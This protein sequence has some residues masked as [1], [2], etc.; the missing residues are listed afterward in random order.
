VARAQRSGRSARNVLAQ[1]AR[2]E[3]RVRRLSRHA[4]GHELPS[5]ARPTVRALAG[6]LGPRALV[7]Y[8]ESD[9]ELTAVT[10]ADGRLRLHPLGPAAAV[11]E[12]LE[13]LRFGLAR[14]AQLGR[15]APQHAALAGGAISS[16]AALERVLVEPL[17]DVLG[18][19]ELV[20]VPTGA[21][22]ALPW[23]MLPALRGRA[24]SVAP[25][26]A[27]WWALHSRPRVRARR[28]VIA[29]AGPRLRHARAEAIAV[30]TQYQRA[31][32]LTGAEATVAATLRALDGAAVAHL[33]CHGRVRADS[34]LFSSLELADGQLN[35]YELARLRRAPQLIVLSACD[36]AVS[37]ARPGNELLGFAGALLDMGTRTIVASVVPVPDAAARR[38]MPA[39]HRELAAGTPAADALAR[40]QARLPPR[41]A[42][43][44]GFICLGTQ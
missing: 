32:T 28:T 1:Q 22:H 38:V 37:D 33:A 23:A 14:L 7:E 35:A 44:A 12:Q 42:A 9:G 5:R 2:V 13:W 8:I 36:L 30:A 26:A 19:R 17:R 15:R 27:V 10:L 31:T 43:L 34:P 39:L 25:S 29:V 6:A 4:R 21:L 20:L 3:T 40:A 41:D 24:V 18:D 11:S 16:A